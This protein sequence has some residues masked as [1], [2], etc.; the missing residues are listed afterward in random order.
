MSTPFRVDNPATGELAFEV[1]TLDAGDLEEV[2]DRAARAQRQWET[3]TIPVRISAVERFIEEFKREGEAIAREIT[4]QM[5][6]PLEQARGEIG[7]VVQR[8]RHMC[9]IAEEALAP[10]I[11]DGGDGIHRQITRVPAGIVLDIAAW[12]YPLLVAVNAVVPAVLAGNAVLIKHSPRTPLCANR[13]A[14]A[15]QAAG[16]PEGL[17]QALHVDHATCAHVIQ[18]PRV[19]AISFTGSVG[20]GREV[21]L[22]AA[23]HRFID[24]GLELGGKDPAYVAQDA[25]LEFA[26][27]NVME[28]ALYNAGQ[29]C[30]AVERAYVHRSLH[31]RFVEGAID[32]LA[33][34]TPGDPMAAGTTLGPMALPGAPAFLA[35][36]IA[37]ARSRGAEVRA[38]GEALDGPGRFFAPTLLTNVDHSMRVM[39]EESF[40]PLLGIMAVEDDAEAV[41][42]MNDSPFGLT[43]SIWTDDQERA[44]AIGHQLVTG[45][46]FQ[47]RCDALDPSLPWAG[48]RDSGRG[49][50]LSR[51]GFDTF[52]RFKSFHLRDLG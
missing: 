31:D 29:S 45:T 32:A 19:G 39:T 8:S 52:T 17:V 6:K 25:D 26:I 12:N 44:L 34:W 23:R 7:G 28:G 51:H 33:A 37:D 27:A 20:G 22:E 40:G 49:A 1:P 16:V 30:C 48:A 2:L 4:L 38:G 36:Q 15:F 10:E 14:D 35:S 43:A 41:R 18:D 13:F 50:T 24:V 11:I 5:G 21:L 9:R 47:N 42:L 46:V 3:T